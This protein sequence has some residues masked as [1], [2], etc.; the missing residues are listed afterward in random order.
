M[1]QEKEHDLGGGREC[2]GAPV[3]FMD[4]GS[5]SNEYRVAH[6]FMIHSANVCSVSLCA[7]YYAWNWGYVSEQKQYGPSLY[8][9][10]TLV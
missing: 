9:A 10:S 1:P 4:V 2:P 6:L 5:W 8:G 3:E 7:R